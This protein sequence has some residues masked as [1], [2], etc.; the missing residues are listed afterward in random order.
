MHAVKYERITAIKLLLEH[1]AD[2]TYQFSNG[3]TP[4]VYAQSKKV[5][6]ILNAHLSG[7]EL[8]VEAEDVSDFYLLLC[9]F[10]IY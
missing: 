1:G 5:R 8:P 2:P 6:N 9:G 4:L 7:D 3:R 10:I